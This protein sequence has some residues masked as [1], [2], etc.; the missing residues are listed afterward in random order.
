MRHAVLLA[1]SLALSLALGPLLVTGCSLLQP[2][3]GDEPAQH[4]LDARPAVAASARQE[5]VLA[6]S[7][8]RAAPGFDT[9][10]LVYVQRPHAL[11]H[12]ATHRWADTPA[13]MLGPLLARTLEDAGGFRAIVQASG[14]VPA[15][16]RLDTEIVQLRHSFLARPSRAELTL[17]VQLVDIAGRRVLATRYIEQ[18]Q[19]ASTGDPTGGV[20]AANAALARALAEVAAFCAEAA[21]DGRLRKLPSRTGPSA[22]P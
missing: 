21:A 11:D 1:L 13:R 2:A 17:R 15:D 4:L 19:E 5:L 20:D 22:P 14:A 18:T 7:A 9:A 16:L 8:P 6:L 3:P 10:A 12:Y